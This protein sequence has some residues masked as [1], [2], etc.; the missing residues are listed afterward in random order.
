MGNATC[1][2]CK[3]STTE[4]MWKLDK[5]K[6]EN[7][8]TDKIHIF[9]YRDLKNPRNYRLPCL[10][11][12]Q[13]NMERARTVFDSIESLELEEEEKDLIR[14]AK[15]YKITIETPLN[16]GIQLN[17]IFAI[18]LE[19]GCFPIYEV[20]ETLEEAHNNQLAPNIQPISPATQAINDI[21]EEHRQRTR[22]NHR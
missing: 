13:K 4:G 6:I 20:V 10:S 5:N 2:Q 1:Q 9:P 12:R 8:R 21:V 15:K 3:K 16:T 11:C 7:R 19:N 14:N 17:V 22:L 18:S